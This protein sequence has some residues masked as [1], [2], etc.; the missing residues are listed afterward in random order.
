MFGN[1]RGQLRRF[2]ITAWQKRAQNHALSPLERIVADT[3]A[4][5]P[6][7]HALLNDEEAAVGSDFAG[8]HEGANPFLHMGMHISLREQLGADHPA[9]I[10]DLYREIASRTADI[11]Q[12]EHRMMECLGKTLW[13]AQTRNATPDDRAYL[14]CLRR[15]AGA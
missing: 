7:Y 10:R 1:D 6:E 8:T 11:H 2:F 4:Q 12:A 14:E 9:G 3:V 15:L 5:H 13:E